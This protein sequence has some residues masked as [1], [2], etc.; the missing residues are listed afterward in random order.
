MVLK[1]PAEKRRF[2]SSS[3]HLLHSLWHD[4]TLLAAAGESSARV[5]TGFFST[6]LSLSV[7]TRTPV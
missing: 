7:L 1:L 3:V 6:S 4:S 5:G 2:F